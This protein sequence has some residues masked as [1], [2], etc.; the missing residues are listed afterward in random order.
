MQRIIIMLY[1]TTTWSRCQNYQEQITRCSFLWK[2]ATE[3]DVS[4][5][6]SSNRMV[7]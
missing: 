2:L 4:A 7:F 5:Q 6:Y 3:A 1:F